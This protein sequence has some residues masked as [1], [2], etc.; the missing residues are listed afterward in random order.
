MGE[1]WLREFF[2]LCFLLVLKKNRVEEILPD[3]FHHQGTGN[4]FRGA[5][6][7]LY[8]SCP[9]QIPS[10]CWGW[11]NLIFLTRCPLS[12]A[13]PGFKRGASEEPTHLP[14]KPSPILFFLQSRE[15]P[16]RSQLTSLSLSSQLLDSA[17]CQAWEK[18]ESMNISFATRSS[19][20]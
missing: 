8:W 12:Q 13:Y 4:S 17:F 1:K 3:I 20:L 19:T 6:G 5:K 2:G 10:K 9:I 11:S 16:V 7:S 18:T 14:E 15:D